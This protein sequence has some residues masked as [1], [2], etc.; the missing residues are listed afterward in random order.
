MAAGP[1]GLLV[2]DVGRPAA[3]KILGVVASGDF[4]S[5]VALE[6]DFAYVA[7]GNAGVKKIHIGNPASPK[8]EASY[9]TPG[10][11]QNVFVIGTIILVADTNSLILLK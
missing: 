1:S 7:D 4:S 6:G 9:D 2:V 10:E 3:P 8:L 11:A 5:A